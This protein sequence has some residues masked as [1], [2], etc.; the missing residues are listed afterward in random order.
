MLTKQLIDI[1][2][3]IAMGGVLFGLWFDQ[4]EMIGVSVVK[5]FGQRMHF[6][7]MW[8][9]FFAFSIGEPKLILNAKSRVK[10]NRDHAL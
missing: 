5:C 4:V 1:I 10:I 9:R 8:K 7:Q 2:P 6:G 3:K